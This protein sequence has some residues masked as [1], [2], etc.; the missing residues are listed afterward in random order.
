MSNCVR[1]GNHTDSARTI[2][3]STV[4]VP[5]VSEDTLSHEPAATT[6]ATT[7]PALGD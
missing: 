5:A 7:E 3:V 4:L 2:L 6:K 1:E